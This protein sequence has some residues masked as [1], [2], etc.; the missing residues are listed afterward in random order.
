M[1]RLL[2]SFQKKFSVLL[3]L[4]VIIGGI[5][6]AV[7]CGL[8]GLQTGL[9]RYDTGPRAIP[10]SGSQNAPAQSTGANG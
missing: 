4:G 1:S 9:D 10:Q 5:I 6:G 8:W 2:E 3:I 7:V